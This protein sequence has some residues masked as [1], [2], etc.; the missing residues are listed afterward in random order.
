MLYLWSYGNGEAQSPQLADHVKRANFKSLNVIELSVKDM[1]CWAWVLY[2]QFS[3]AVGSA[4][5]IKQFD[6]LG[7]LLL[8]QAMW[9][10]KVSGFHSWCTF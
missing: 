2:N 10:M 5:S 8:P 1:L 4:V 6:L 3:E 9:N 7:S